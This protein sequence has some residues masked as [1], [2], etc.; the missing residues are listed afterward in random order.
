MLVPGFGRVSRAA[1]QRALP[2][3]AK[4]RP[5]E[6]QLFPRPLSGGV[7]ENV[8][9]AGQAPSTSLWRGSYSAGRIVRNSG[10]DGSSREDGAAAELGGRQWGALALLGP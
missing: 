5:C 2:G 3:T 1:R 6:A 8:S 7:T 10:R 9:A 4:P